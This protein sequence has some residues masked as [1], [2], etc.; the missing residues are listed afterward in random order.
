MGRLQARSHHPHGTHLDVV[1]KGSVKHG[2]VSQEGAQVGHSSLHHTLKSIQSKTVFIV[3]EKLRGFRNLQAGANGCIQ[4][5]T[6]G[7][8]C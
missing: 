3:I 5:L 6:A 8:W 1:L 2:Q 4:G 7:Q